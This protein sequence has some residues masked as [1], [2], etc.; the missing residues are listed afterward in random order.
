MAAWQ[1][2]P[3]FWYRW[4]ADASDW[5]TDALSLAAGTNHLFRFGW[6]VVNG[7]GPILTADVSFQINYGGGWTEFEY[8]KNTQAGYAQFPEVYPTPWYDKT[9]QAW[10]AN[11]GGPYE[12]RAVIDTD[13][14]GDPI[15]STIAV[16]I[17]A[18]GAGVILGEADLPERTATAG[19]E[20]RTVE[21]TTTADLTAAAGVDARTA[22]A[23]LSG[24]LAVTAGAESKTLE[25]GLRAGAAIAP[26]EYLSV[27]ASLPAR[28]L[29]A[30]LEKREIVAPAFE[31]NLTIGV[32]SE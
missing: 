19:A 11:T 20:A 6:R 25:A 30:G 27:D 29:T 2:G 12:T 9:F 13:Y 4:D 15:S 16:T 22:D 7:S 17:T 3:V 5:V 32:P 26:M 28:V 10:P 24:A 23:D 31:R 18:A 14:E 8:A 1:I 21:A